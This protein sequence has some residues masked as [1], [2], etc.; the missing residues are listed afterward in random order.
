MSPYLGWAITEISSTAF[1]KDRCS[2]ISHEHYED[3]QQYLKPLPHSTAWFISHVD[4][5]ESGTETR[6][7]QY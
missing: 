3:F 4:K 6:N 7:I 5:I 1:W 2:L